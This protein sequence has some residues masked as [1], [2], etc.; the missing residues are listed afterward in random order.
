MFNALWFSSCLTNVMCI[1][2]FDLGG[3]NIG[4]SQEWRVL[5]AYRAEQFGRRVGEPVGEKDMYGRARDAMTPA[6][7]YTK[8]TDPDLALS[9]AA[10]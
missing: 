5:P 9:L 6:L 1:G 8:G 4:C 7:R 2:F 10:H 3:G